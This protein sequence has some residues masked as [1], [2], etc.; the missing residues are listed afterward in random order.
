VAIFNR[1]SE[2][3]GNEYWQNDQPDMVSTANTMLDTDD[4]KTYFGSS[5]DTNQAFIEH[6]YKNTLNKTYDEDKDGIDYWVREL[7][8]GKSRG[9]VVVALINALKA[10]ENSNDP[11]AKEA[12]D[13]FMNRVEVSNYTADNFEGKDLPTIMPDYGV[14]LG[15]ENGDLGV[16]ADHAT[17]VTAEETINGYI[18]A[19]GDATML[20]PDTDI[21]SGTHF[22][23]PMEYVPDGSDRVLTL[24]D[25]DQLT[26]IGDNA[27]LDVTMGNVNADEGTTGV[28]TPT[29][30]N[31]KNINIDWTGNTRTLDLRYTDDTLGSIHIDKI[32]ADADDITVDNISSPVSD[33]RVA[34]AAD[35]NTDIEFGYRKGALAGDSDTL[36][37]DLDSVIAGD[38]V[39]SSTVDNS[40]GFEKAIINASN[41]VY[42]NSL[43]VNELEEVEIKGTDVLQIVSLTPTSPTGGEDEYNLLNAN[44]GVDVNNN[45]AGIRTID[46]S[47]FKGNLTL[48]ISDAM[49]RRVDPDNSGQP[50]YGEVKGGEGNDIFYT[51]SAIAGN[52][53]I[54][55][56]HNIIDGGAG[57]NTLISTVGGIV[58]DADIRSIQTLELRDQ[59]GMAT[60]DMDAFDDKLTKVFMRDESAGDTTF[61]LNDVTKSIAENGLVLAH[62]ITTAGN[63]TV[64]VELNDAKGDNTVVLTVVNDKNQ[65]T[66][67]D[68]TLNAHGKVASDVVENI[69]I[70]DNDTESNILTL[71]NITEH[72][73]IITL[74]GGVAGNTFTVN[75]TMNAK[76]VDASGQA[77]DLRLT[78]G[79][80]IAPI[81]PIDQEIKLGTGNDVLTFDGVNELNNG[82]VITDAGGEDTIRAIFNSDATPN[83]TG[84]ENFQTAA[85]S[86]I[87]L[88][89][90]NTDVKNLV[91]LSNTAVDNSGDF[92]SNGVAEMDSKGES[93]ATT[94]IITLSNTS[95]SEL[96]FFADLDTDDVLGDDA[97]QHVFNGVTLS[98]NSV[99]NLTVNVNSSLDTVVNGASDILNAQGDVLVPAY[100]IGKITSHGNTSMNIVVGDEAQSAT[101]QID[102]IYGNNMD[103][104]TAEAKGNLN[105]GT[106]SGDN[107]VGSLKSVDM[108]KV[109]GDVTANIISLGDNGIVELAD[110][111]HDVSVLTSS[112][113][114]ITIISGD[115]DSILVGSAQ[116]DTISAGNGDNR[117]HGDRGD[118]KIFTGSGND[119][120]TAKD[121]NDTIDFGSGFGIYVDN[122][123][124]SQ[125]GTNA[126]NAVT[127]NSGFVTTLIDVKGDT[128]ITDTQGVLDFTRIYNGDDLDFADVTNIKNITDDVNQALAVGQGSELTVSWTGSQI[129]V[130][131]ATLDGGAAKEITGSGTVTGNNDNANLAIQTA[132]GSATFSGL[133]GNDVYIVAYDDTRDANGNYQSATDVLTFDG[134]DGNDAVVAGMGAD[135]IT[136]GRGAD[137]IV[138]QNRV[139]FNGDGDAT[140]GETDDVFDNQTDTIHIADGESTIAGFDIISGF[141]A[142][143]NNE[144]QLELATTTIATSGTN[145]SSNGLI[146][147]SVGSNGLVTFMDSAGNNL[148]VGTAKGEISLQDALAYLA[149]NVGNA[150]EG[151]TVMFHYDADGDGNIDGK[152]ASFIFQDGANDTV[153]ELLHNP[154]DGGGANSA[155]FTGLST[156]ATDD[157]VH[158]I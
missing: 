5:L 8:G 96:N 113:K 146:Q 65:T 135:D 38:I 121:G 66:T 125:D 107:A 2:G 30:K 34:N 64:D 89:M 57:E 140:I 132:K 37:L 139:S 70:H 130:D 36:N 35:N 157:M 27:T 156:S 25:E 29:L 95:L 13:Q 115:G 49:G 117:L 87:T 86:N 59:G 19:L 93:I 17:V 151:A 41:G 76:T 122:L 143:A 110:G 153:V 4:A 124:T 88:D 75:G 82:D 62:G 44:S 52:N 134:G 42:I 22:I 79:D 31:I 103:T 114:D 149:Q 10:Y 45:S 109:G 1:A 120:I 116:D 91:L 133:D 33:L 46:A 154:A 142:S 98:N 145:Y 129:N 3:A 53:S 144:D 84:I 48:D 138:L 105:L 72:T 77:S 83:L 40:E 85:T 141:Q 102:N 14:K 128:E 55:G 56:T 32:T 108:T 90:G 137:M 58:N 126:T 6:I 18:V 47:Q 15:F 150:Q 69:T 60:V 50:F 68:Y 81:A 131:R 158:L 67:F 104:L 123:R 71:T 9:E 12:Y 101:T 23:A 24:Q 73:G 74:D 11:K 127:L 136:G 94:D 112:G 63:Q 119:F 61:D 39:Q 106:V 152:D 80:T 54:D 148:I 51:S 20:T 92:G 118:N 7:D 16:T 155:T 21:L 99:A 97:R 78:V 28:V 26:G 147:A 43:S 111:N 100:H